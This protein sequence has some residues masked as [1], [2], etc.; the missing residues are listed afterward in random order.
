MSGQ[1]RDFEPGESGF[2]NELALAG[3]ACPSPARLQA[4]AL[5]ALPKE[6]CQAL[7]RHLAGCAA[8]RLLAGDMAKWQPAPPD[9]RDVEALWRR[10]AGRA[11]E[12]R[13]R[14]RRPHWAWFS[15]PVA[16]AAAVVLVLRLNQAATAP[17]HP[18]PPSH[19]SIA[20]PLYDLGAMAAVE[21]APVRLPSGALLLWRGTNQ[22]AVPAE[23]RELVAAL[24][25]YQKD[26][27]QQAA[28]LLASLS[29]RYPQSFEAAFYWGAS[30][31]MM[32]RPAEAAAP[33]DRARTLGN[34]QQREEASWYLSLAH[35]RAGSIRP[36]RPLLQQLCSA[37]GARAGSAC[38]VLRRLAAPVFISPSR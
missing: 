14:R 18:P 38:A 28:G 7:E 12:L 10:I 15:V 5:D 25:P 32:E 33:L 24:A 1:D 19:A 35:L 31:L 22:P 29:N 9:Q 27:F 4:F 26:D 6:Q 16:A 17:D 34:P 8:C 23:T 3:A 13:P 30:L 21:K 37:G 11:P 36:A 2:L 20:V